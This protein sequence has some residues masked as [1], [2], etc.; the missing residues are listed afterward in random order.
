[1]AEPR[2]DERR[3]RKDAIRAENSE[4]KA[5]PERTERKA[6]PERGERPERLVRPRRDEHGRPDRAEQ[7]RRQREA[8]DDGTVGFGDD[9][10]AFM[11]IS[12]RA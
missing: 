1:A 2:S 10:P 11:K 9:V 7:N 6:S 8:D 3:A 12:G 5:A 4:R